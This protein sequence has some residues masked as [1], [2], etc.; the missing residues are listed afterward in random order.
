MEGIEFVILFFDDR[1]HL[2]T[3]Y[4][5]DYDSTNLPYLLKSNRKPY[6]SH[7]IIKVK[8]HFIEEKKLFTEVISYNTGLIDFPDYQHNFF[9]D[10]ESIKELQFNNIDTNA[11]VYTMASNNSNHRIVAKPRTLS[12]ERD[13]ITQTSSFVF[14]GPKRDIDSIVPEPIKFSFKE[15]VVLGFKSLEFHDGFVEFRKEILPIK[16]TVT[17]QIL[18]D[19][20][21]EV[22]DPIK[23]YFANCLQTKQITI[24]LHVDMIDGVIV[25]QSAKSIDIDKINS[26][27]IENVRYDYVTNILNRKASSNNSQ[28]LFSKEE[29]FENFNDGILKVNSFY[30]DDIEFFHELLKIKKTKHYQ[31]LDYLSEK[32]LSSRMK[33]RFCLTPL[34]FIFL[35]E[36]ES[37]YF[38][39]WETLDTKEATYVWA[40]PNKEFDLRDFLKKIDDKVSI[41]KT[42]GKRGYLDLKE[43]YFFKVN[44]ENYLKPEQSFEKWQLEIESILNGI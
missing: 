7:W 42:N 30:K 44:H 14:S 2:T 4:S 33:L 15:T 23:N 38:L 20:I 11:L 22:Y 34:S 17:F 16:K 18:N 28:N 27:F 41:I 5:L 35:I 25:N 1:V 26:S 24:D 40:T 36:G 43:E 13:M 21:L 12:T 32:H 8:K 19:D 3:S 10:F 39:I 37:A 31:Y 29:L 6:L 9:M